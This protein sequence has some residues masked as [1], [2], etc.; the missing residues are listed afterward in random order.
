MCKVVKFGGSSLADAKQFEK[1]YDII[2]SDKS[3]KYVVPSAPG[4]RFKDD[5]KVTDLLY[6][7]YHCDNEEEI[8][9]LFNEIKQR[10]QDIIDGLHLDLNLDKEFDIIKNNFRN[11]EGLDYAVSRGEY[12]NGIVLAHYLGFEFIDAKDVIFIDE[13]GTYDSKMTDPILSDI[14]S[15]KEYVVIPGFYG[16]KNDG[17]G[18]IKVLSRGGSDGT[19]SIVAKNAHVNLYENWTDV[20]G[21]LLADPRIVKNPDVIETITYKELR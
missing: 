18:K 14:L 6:S 7:A 16:S 13:H 20:S 15:Q 17:R 3:R 11:N 10:Y 4:K 19:G 2:K 9:Q 5:T 1:V 12:L 21:C 8:I